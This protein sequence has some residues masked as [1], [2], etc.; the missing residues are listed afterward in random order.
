[1]SEYGKVSNNNRVITREVEIIE[2][3]N[4]K[5]MRV[6]FED[7]D[8]T[9]LRIFYMAAQIAMSRRL[10]WS[11]DQNGGNAEYYLEFSRD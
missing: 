2:R 7:S 9:Q 8:K 6:S 4:Y 5:C 1:M 10:G 3:I 11:I